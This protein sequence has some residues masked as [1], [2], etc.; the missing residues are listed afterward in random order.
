VTPAR[1]R[2]IPP[3]VNFHS[4]KNR[5]LLRVYH[6]TPANLVA[7]LPFTLCRDAMALVYVLLRERRSLPAYHWLWRNR[8]ALLERRRA[9]QRRKTHSIEGWFL[10]AQSGNGAPAAAAPTPRA[11]S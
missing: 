3:E 1:R 11:S 5:Y 7:T 8:R 9:I 6:Q 4:L 2:D 10:R